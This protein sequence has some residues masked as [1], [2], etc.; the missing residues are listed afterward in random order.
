MLALTDVVFSVM[1]CAVAFLTVYAFT[2]RKPNAVFLGKTY[3]VAIF[4][5]N[6][7]SLMGGG[8][9]TADLVSPTQ[10]IRGIYIGAIVF[11]YLTFSDQVHEVIP[12][13]FRKLSKKDYGLVAALIVVPLLFA[14]LGGFGLG[15]KT[16]KEK[17]ATTLV[18]ETKL[19]KGELTD[20][21]VVFTPPTGFACKKLEEKGL[22][23]YTM[24]SANGETVTLCS[25]FE[26]NQS[27]INVNTYWKNFE[28][29]QAPMTD[30]E[31]ITSEKK[32][33]NDF[34][35]Y[36]KEKKYVIGRAIVFWKFA[37]VFDN[38]SSKVCILSCYDQGDSDYFNDIL[39]SIRFH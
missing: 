9:E 7:L 22:A 8:F 33:I 13:E 10:T 14:L 24:E 12:K 29:P 25:D 6:I 19:A 26:P 4:V 20:G 31:L 36:Y 21:R 30:S 15:V 32:T 1:L 16:Q 38:A 11:A 34:T 37:M 35:Y 18:N 2:Q 39:K 28:D 3:V 27:A 5:S 23:Y 17:E